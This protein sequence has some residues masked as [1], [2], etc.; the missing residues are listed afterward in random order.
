[1]PSDD[2]KILYF[3]DCHY[4]SNFAGYETSWKINYNRWSC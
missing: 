4:F 3:S 2:N 1:M